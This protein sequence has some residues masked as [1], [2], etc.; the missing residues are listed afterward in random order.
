MLVFALPHELARMS[1]LFLFIAQPY[2]DWHYYNQSILSTLEN[3][4]SCSNP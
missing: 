1:V 2:L 3:T 4:Y